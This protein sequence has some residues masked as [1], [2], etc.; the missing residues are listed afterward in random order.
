[1]NNAS[2]VFLVIALGASA[3]G[4]AALQGTLGGSSSGESDIS[5]T[6]GSLV[7]ISGIADLN[8]GTMTT[9]GSDLSAYDDIC[10]FSSTSSYSVTVTSANASFELSD[11]ATGSIPYAL[12][13]TDDT[14]TPTTIS[15]GDT[16]DSQTGDQANNNCDSGTNA[17]FSISVTSIDF[18]SATPGTYTDKL[19]LFI[20]PE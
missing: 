12:T 4:Q 8:L 3:T 13:W 6:K 7:M 1:M 11:G 10:V 15:Y 14:G 9:A 19:T 17:S 2:R 20:A 16:L 5:V 18:N